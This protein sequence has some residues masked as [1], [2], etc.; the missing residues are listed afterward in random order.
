MNQEMDQGNLQQLLNQMMDQERQENEFRSQ[1]V[2]LMIEEKDKEIQYLKSEMFSSTQKQ[3][4]DLMVQNEKLQ[5]E[6]RE[7][8][9]RESYWNSHQQ[10]KEGYLAL[11]RKYESL[12]EKYRKMEALKNSLNDELLLMA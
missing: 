11:Y 12:S 8:Q 3:L 1:R 10:D 4:K 7:C 9:A 2:L 5:M 6:L